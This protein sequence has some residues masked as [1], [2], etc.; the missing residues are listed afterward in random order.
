MDARGWT[1]RAFVARAAAS[2]AALLL[3]FPLSADGLAALG[4][5]DRERLASWLRTLRTEGLADAA[6]PL[7]RAVARVG[8]LSL[9]APYAAATLEHYLADG[10]SPEAEPLTLHLLLAL[11][12][13]GLGIVMVNR[14]AP[15]AGAKKAASKAA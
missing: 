5:D 13:V 2:A 8:E 1:R 12:G 15:A 14:K 7:G 10:G 3:P 9:G 6:A 11:A 4:E